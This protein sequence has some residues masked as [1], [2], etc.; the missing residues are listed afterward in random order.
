MLTCYAVC[1]DDELIC[2]A[3]V[4]TCFGHMCCGI[5]RLIAS[6]TVMS[7]FGQAC[8]SGLVSSWLILTPLRA[9]LSLIVLRMSLAI[10]FGLVLARLVASLWKEIVRARC[11]TREGP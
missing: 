1:G 4:C 7:L 2:C 6:S 8:S 11:G 9:R 10:A 3:H 5:Y